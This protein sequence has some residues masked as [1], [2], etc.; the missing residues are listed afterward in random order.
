[1][2]DAVVRFRTPSRPPSDRVEIYELALKL[3]SEVYTVVELVAGVE[4][5]FLRDQLDRKSTVIPQLVKQGM[6]CE[7]MVERRAVYTKA[8]RVTLDC[9]AVLDVLGE[10]G[11]I[12]VQALKAAH[13]TAQALVDA[14]APLIV[15]PPLTR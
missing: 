6:G 4:R 13:S 5:F 12:E 7:S 8:K 1:M 10:R 2:N 9:L 15:P 3:S 14:L 11:T